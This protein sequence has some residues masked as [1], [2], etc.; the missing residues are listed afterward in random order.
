MLTSNQIQALSLAD[1]E[2]IKLVESIGHCSVPTLQKIV[3]SIRGH[4]AGVLDGARD[5]EANHNA[6]VPAALAAIE[7]IAAG[8]TQRR[9]FPNGKVAGPVNP[10]DFV[11]VTARGRQLIDASPE[12]LRFMLLQDAL[13]RFD[14]PAN[15]E[16]QCIGAQ[17]PA[18]ARRQAQVGETGENTTRDVEICCTWGDRIQTI[19]VIEEM[20]LEAAGRICPLVAIAD[21]EEGAA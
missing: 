17:C 18:F 13:E 11:N 16:G 10:D 4:L 9:R 21:S 6:G 20:A 2:C 14:C 7:A 15:V 8:D 19:G 12:P 3:A 1:A 5:A